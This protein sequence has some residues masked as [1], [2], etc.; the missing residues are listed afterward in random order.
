MTLT[1]RDV[2]QIAELLADVARIEIM[3]R[4]KALADGDLRH[5]SSA[6]DPVTAA[7]EAAE[8]AITQT[9]PDGHAAFSAKAMLKI[10][11]PRASY[12]ATSRAP[13]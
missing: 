13:T 11:P 5:K 12:F 9:L 3:P 8:R 4:F 10:L 7:D 1:Q 6:F 2:D